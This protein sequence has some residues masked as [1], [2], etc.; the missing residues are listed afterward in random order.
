M[1]S[2]KEEIYLS[3]FDLGPLEFKDHESTVSATDDTFNSMVLES[4]VI[5]NT[6]NNEK[7]HISSTFIMVSKAPKAKI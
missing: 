2:T 4:K 6:V 5:K 3:M 1:L 7:S